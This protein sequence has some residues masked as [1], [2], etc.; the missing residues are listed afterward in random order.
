MFK[1]SIQYVM[2]HDLFH[3]P[4]LSA[5]QLEENEK[6]RKACRWISE[7]KKANMQYTC[8]FT[9]TFPKVYIIAYSTLGVTLMWLNGF[10]IH[11]KSKA[12]LVFIGYLI[13]VCSYIGIWLGL[14]VYSLLDLIKSVNLSK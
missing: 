6:L 4:V 13:Y 9:T 11:N 8:S 5:Y 10:R 12:R 2:I 1:S 7:S 3:T 14:S